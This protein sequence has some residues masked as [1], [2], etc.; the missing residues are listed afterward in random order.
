MNWWY[1]VLGVLSG[2]LG[3]CITMCVVG[4]YVR[5]APVC[6]DRTCARFGERHTSHYHDIGQP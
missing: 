2:S 1:M 4:L 3:A 6:T 5:R